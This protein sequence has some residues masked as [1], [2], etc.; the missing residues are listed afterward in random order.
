MVTIPTFSRPYCLT[1][2]LSIQLFGD[3]VYLVPAAAMISSDVIATVGIGF[4]I[5][6]E[7][8]ATTAP[9]MIFSSRAKHKSAVAI[10]PSC[11]IFWICLSVDLPRVI[12]LYVPNTIFYNLLII[13]NPC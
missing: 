9:S 2:C 12:C 7:G 5:S 4:H 8:P 6:S 13:L 11:E 3:S 1:A 10:P